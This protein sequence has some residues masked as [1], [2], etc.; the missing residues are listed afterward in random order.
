MLSH[1]QL[2][3]QLWKNLSMYRVCQN[4]KGFFLEKTSAPGPGVA[5][6]Q[7]QKAGRKKSYKR[8]LTQA[9]LNETNR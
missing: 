6:K 3:L 9:K 5:K 4:Y 2:A 7:D 8:K 1:A